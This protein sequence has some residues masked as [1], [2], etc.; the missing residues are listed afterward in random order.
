MSDGQLTKVII[1]AFTNKR[2]TEKDS[3]FPEFEVP[4]NPEK[5]SK[6]FKVEY[7]VKKAQGNQGV[8]AKFKSTAPE[9]LTIEFALDGTKTVEGY[10]KKHIDK[11]V[12]QQV[13]ELL[14]TVY[15]MKG[16]IHKPKFLKLIWG[17][18]L[19]FDCI[20]TS[21]DINYTLFHP[22][23]EP[24]R[25]RINASFLNYTEQEKRV[26]REDK[27][28]PD[29]THV[30]KVNEGDSLPLMAY[31]IYGE[32]KF[33]LQIARANQMT[34]FRPIRSGQDI[35]FPPIQKTTEQT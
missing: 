31:K 20:L 28:S 23:G 12:S 17:E 9:E 19:V 5:Y 25:A 33:Y 16:D 35:V 26:L 32:P 15:F 30:R 24:L 14:N 6:N 11:P 29:L 27:K 21:L 34:S 18:H 1:R 10:S 7:E 22:N 2:L 4:I 13:E 3:E 8:D